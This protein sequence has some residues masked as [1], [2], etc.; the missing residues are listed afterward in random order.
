MGKQFRPQGRGQA[1]LCRNSSRVGEVNFAVGP[2]RHRR[3]AG[4]G[5]AVD[6]AHHRLHLYTKAVR[7][8]LVE[9]A[10]VRLKGRQPEGA[11]GRK[12]KIGDL[13][14]RQFQY[15]GPTA[16][17][18]LHP[19]QH[20]HLGQRRRRIHPAVLHPDG[21]AHFVGL[22][23]QRIG[24]VG[25][26][27]LGRALGH[28]ARRIGLGR[29][30]DGPE[31]QR[32][33]Q[34]H[35]GQRGEDVAGHPEA[36]EHGFPLDGHLGLRLGFLPGGPG[37]DTVGAAHP[38]VYEERRLGPHGDR[39]NEQDQ[40]KFNESDAHKQFSFSRVCSYQNSI[41]HLPQK[42]QLA[43][44]PLALPLGELSSKARLRG[45]GCIAVAI[46]SRHWIVVYYT[47]RDFSKGFTQT[48]QKFPIVA[49]R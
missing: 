15:F 43:A 1:V 31:Q 44:R 21:I 42:K 39:R 38:A 19:L 46:V 41:A 27:G 37:A 17:V 26:P 34:R 4:Q 22:Q 16:S 8:H 49:V 32:I 23:V 25:S 29:R 13:P 2:H 3:R 5:P 33:H 6:L 14:F 45:R 11:V 30:G 7:R 10:A 35:R 9:L 48:S 47:K 18:R 28:G 36:V 40:D 20:P 12:I 24:G